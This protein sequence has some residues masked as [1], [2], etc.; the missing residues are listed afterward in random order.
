M[1]PEKLIECLGCV[2]EKAAQWADPLTQAMECYQITSP[3]RQAAFLATIGHESGI[4]TCLEENLNYGAKGLLATF[5]THFSTAQADL[6]ARK[7]EK[8]ANH[9]YE[10]RMGNGAE[11]TGDGWKYRGR[12]LIQLTGRESYAACGSALGLDLIGCPERLLEEVP[13]AMSA[14]WEWDSKRC[15]GA[16]DAGDFQRVT[17]L[18]NGGLNGYEARCTLWAKAK[19]ALGV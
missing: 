10:L 14:G 6:Y 5:P 4:F 15:N 7:P 1:T 9:A 19:T 13:A 8:I 16:A 3:A 11:S 2:P 18:I 12:G 17:K